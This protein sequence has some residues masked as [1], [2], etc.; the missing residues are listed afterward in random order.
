MDAE[1]LGQLIDD[2]HDADAGLESDQHRF[3]DEI[4][5]ESET[6]DGRQDQDR[7]H[8]QRQK[9]SSLQQRG[10]IAAGHAMPSSVPTRIAIVV[11]VVTLIG[12]DVPS[13]A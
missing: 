6:Q 8:H 13:T 3:G 7:A 4:G 5:D 12:R 1:D 2:D 9:R 10:R 11:V